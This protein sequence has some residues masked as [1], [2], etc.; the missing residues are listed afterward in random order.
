MYVLPKVKLEFAYIVSKYFRPNDP[1]FIC[2]HLSSDPDFLCGQ[3]S[4]SECYSYNLGI[5]FKSLINY[6][7]IKIN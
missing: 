3:L 5:V 7:Q 2:G 4:E 1:A 6:Y